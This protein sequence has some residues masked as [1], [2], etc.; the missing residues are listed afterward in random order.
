MRVKAVLGV[1]G[2]LLSFLFLLET[3]LTGDPV[4][5]FC[6]SATHLVIQFFFFF[7]QGVAP[8]NEITFWVCKTCEKRAC[9]VAV[10]HETRAKV[11]WNLEAAAAELLCS[12]LRCHIGDRCAAN[13]C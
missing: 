4:T 9:Q 7:D 12:W 10:T 13:A 2:A 1:N 8:A 11:V 5:E 6:V 3:R